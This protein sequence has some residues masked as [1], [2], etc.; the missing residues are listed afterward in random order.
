MRL[1]LPR[2]AMDANRLDGVTG[3]VAFDGGRARTG[4]ELRIAA[5][6]AT[7]RAV[8]YTHLDVYKR[9]RRITSR[10]WIAASLIDPSLISSSRIR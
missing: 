1:A 7:L 4:G 5:Q 9:Q 10:T 8:S 2:V 6:S 3:T